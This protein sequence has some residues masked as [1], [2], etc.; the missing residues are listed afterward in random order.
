[1]NL[2]RIVS[3]VVGRVNPFVPVELLVSAGYTKAPSGKQVPKYEAPVTVMAQVQQ[4]TTKEIQHLDAM[5]IQ[6]SGSG[7]YM[8]GFVNGVVR[9]TKKG[10]D[11]ITLPDGQTY[12]VT[13]VLEQWSDW[14]KVAVTLQNGA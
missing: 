9:V 11:L 12:L 6:N 2:H 3:G 8:R 14:C 5:N 7:I 10:G 1:M 13:A 4:L